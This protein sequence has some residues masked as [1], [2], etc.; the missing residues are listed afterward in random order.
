MILAAWVEAI[1]TVLAFIV[2]GLA[3]L[4][5]WRQLQID[6]D[7]SER[8]NAG[9]LSAWWA[10]AGGK[11]WGVVVSN[12]SQTPFHDVNV[13]CEGNKA[14][15]SKPIQF[16][17]LPPGTYFVPSN[18]FSGGGA[19]SSGWGAACTYDAI[20]GLG[21]VVRSGVHKVCSIEFTD[22]EGR[23]WQWTPL[24]GLAQRRRP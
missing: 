3:A 18:G 1:A 24:A 23:D 11:T 22:F 5:A 9:G 17:V 21:P 4:Y 19:T 16:L 15:G 14:A 13:V 6:R 7:R 2:A 8:V 12:A 10:Q 20:D